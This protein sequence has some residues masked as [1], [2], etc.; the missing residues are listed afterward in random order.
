MK[1][2]EV[3]FTCYPVCHMAMVFVPAG[4]IVIIDK[5]RPAPLITELM[6]PSFFLEFP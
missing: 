2:T 5:R 1:I 3:A 6:R 4:N